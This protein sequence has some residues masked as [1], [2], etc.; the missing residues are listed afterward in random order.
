MTALYTPLSILAAGM[1]IATGLFLG[2]SHSGSS[3]AASGTHGATPAVAVDIA[4][5]KTDGLPYIG[6]TNAPVVMAFW[7][8][9]QCPYC[10]AF[11]VGGIP[12]IKTPAAMPVLLQQ[13]V[14]SGKLKI[15]FKDFPFLGNDSLTAGEY[16]RSI[17]GVRRT[18]DFGEIVFNL[19]DADL[20][21]RTPEDSRADFH[22]LFD[23]EAVLIQDFRIVLEDE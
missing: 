2:L 10:K 20:M 1:L 8:D 19:I 18:D 22:A 13:Y 21:S 11:E 4:K 16:A 14:N 23:L 9:F 5:V 7:S 15:V 17:W 3:A 12:Q 6:D